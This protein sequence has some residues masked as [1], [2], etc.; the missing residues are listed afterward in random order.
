MD[1]FS[2][3]L[4]PL[5]WCPQ[6]RHQ[7]HT[8]SPRHMGRL[9]RASAHQPLL[10]NRTKQKYKTQKQAS[11]KRF[12]QDPPGILIPEVERHA[13]WRGFLKPDFRVGKLR[14]SAGVLSSAG[15]R[16]SRRLAPFTHSLF[17]EYLLCGCVLL[18][19]EDMETAV[20]KT[21]KISIHMDLPF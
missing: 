13:E 9:A 2:S 11:Q 10:P 12:V 20:S 8:G 3:L 7:G 19:T 17:I 21:D 16:M 4:E 15:T 5:E 1:S 14:Q 6:T 18:D